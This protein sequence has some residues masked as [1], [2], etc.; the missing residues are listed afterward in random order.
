MVLRKINPY[1]FFLIAAIFLY[2]LN[3]KPITLNLS[4]ADCIVI[5]LF[6]LS[7]IKILNHAFSHGVYRDTFFIYFLYLTSLAFVGMYA[8][9]IEKHILALAQYGFVFLVLV[10]LLCVTR[11]GILT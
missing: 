9:N 5:F 3:F 7:P 8:L 4:V 11:R 6:I 2:A 1:E 10:P